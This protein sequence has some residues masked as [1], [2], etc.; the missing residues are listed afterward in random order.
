MKNLLLILLL[1]T[2]TH[3]TFAGKKSGGYSSHRTHSSYT[4]KHN[5]NYS[6]G[7]ARDKHGRIQRSAKAREQFKKQTGYPHGRKGYVIDHIIPLSKG[8]R[9]DPSNMQW[10][11]KEE[12][13]EKDKWERGQ[14]HNTH[15]KKHKRI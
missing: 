10:Q 14:T 1:L 5:S 12:A 6:Y 4:T 15:Y 13:K 9:D 2:L 3:T 8:G 7:V 11:T